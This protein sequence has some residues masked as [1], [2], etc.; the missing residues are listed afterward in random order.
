MKKEKSVEVKEI[1]CQH[2]QTPMKKTKKVKQ[3]MALQ[4]LDR[5]GDGF[6][7]QSLQLPRVKGVGV[8]LSADFNRQE[9]VHWAQG[10]G[11]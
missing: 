4:L 11:T 1:D 9:E 6:I 3:S 2:C 8:K 10:G 7:S 5:K